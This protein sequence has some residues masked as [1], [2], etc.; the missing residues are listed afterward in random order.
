M[1]VLK[2]MGTLEKPTAGATD[3]KEVKRGLK[4]EEE[5]ARQKRFLDELGV[6]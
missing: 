4:V 3:A 5:R 2:A 6:F 1:S